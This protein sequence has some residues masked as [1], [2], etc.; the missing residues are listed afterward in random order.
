MTDWGSNE[1]MS[2]W[3][4]KYVSTNLKSGSR[5]YDKEFFLSINS[6]LA[7]QPELQPYSYAI[8]VSALV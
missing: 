5:A 2:Q 7:A 4:A 8:V 3:D 6:E 1:F